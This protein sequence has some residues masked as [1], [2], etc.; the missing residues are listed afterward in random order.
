MVQQFFSRVIRKTE[1]NIPMAK[2]YST[3]DYHFD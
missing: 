1:Q 3:R 2:K